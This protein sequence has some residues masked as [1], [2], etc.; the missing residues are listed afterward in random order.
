MSHLV[1]QPLG[2][3]PP[4]PGEPRCERAHKVICSAYASASSFA[5][6]YKDRVSGE[7]TDEDED[8][9]R[10]MLLFAGS[11]LDAMVKQLIADAL[12][13]VIEQTSIPSAASPVG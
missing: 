10:A 5:H 3:V 2:P 1:G 12:P 9:L 7:P 13:G 8:L 4:P 6:I 11:G